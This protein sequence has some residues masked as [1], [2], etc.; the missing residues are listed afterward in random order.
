MFCGADTWPAQPVNE[1]KRFA[2]SAYRIT[3]C[4]QRPDNKPQQ[5]SSSCSQQQWS[6]TVHTWQLVGWLTG[7]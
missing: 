5:Y 6:H 3:T 2:T 7:V 1:K 4:T